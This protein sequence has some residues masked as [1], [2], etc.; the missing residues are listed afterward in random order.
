MDKR[1]RIALINLHHGLGQ[2]RKDAWDGFAHHLGVDRPDLTFREV[3]TMQAVYRYELV[4]TSQLSLTEL[5]ARIQLKNAITSQTV[6]SLVEKGL[7]VRKNDDD[8]RRK[9]IISLTEEGKKLAEEMAAFADKYLE[10][11]LSP[12]TDTERTAL[13]KIAEKMNPTLPY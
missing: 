9:V 12:L 13:F 5:A 8:N 3:S 10:K 1:E 6:S 2:C 11:F 7:M 4:N